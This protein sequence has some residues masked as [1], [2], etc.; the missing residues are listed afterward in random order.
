[1]KCQK[2][3]SVNICVRVH[4]RG[5][6]TLKKY[7][8][9]QGRCIAK[10]RS[11][12]YECVCLCDFMLNKRIGRFFF[13]LDL[14]PLLQISMGFQPSTTKRRNNGIA[15]VARSQHFFS[16]L[17]PPSVTHESADKCTRINGIDL[18][19]NNKHIHRTTKLILNSENEKT[20]NVSCCIAIHECGW[21][22]CYRR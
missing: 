4:T 18:K 13:K 5:C 19:S 7:K 15:L 9:L 22:R 16:L 6:C 12:K 17:C 8:L 1:M 3:H 11:C 14:L 20:F 21:S 2:W 10:C